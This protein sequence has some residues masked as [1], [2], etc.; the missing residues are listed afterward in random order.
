MCVYLDGYA[1]TFG[2]A[3]RIIAFCMVCYIFWRF[4][5][6]IMNYELIM[7]RDTY[8][9]YIYICVFLLLYQNGF[10]Y[11]PSPLCTLVLANNGKLLRIRILHNPNWSAKSLNRAFNAALFT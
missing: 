8:E 10:K 5:R 6:D 3:T 4:H 9:V 7:M 11:N 2:A 1:C